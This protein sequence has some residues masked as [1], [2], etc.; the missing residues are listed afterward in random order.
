MSGIRSHADEASLIYGSY[1]CDLIRTACALLLSSPA[2]CYRAQVLFQRFNEAIDRALTS[3][4]LQRNESSGAQLPGPLSTPSVVTMLKDIM[5]YPDPE[6]KALAVLD[7]YDDTVIY[8]AGSAVLIAAKMEDSPIKIK[9]VV[10]VFDRINRRRRRDVMLL[11]IHSDPALFDLF[12]ANVIAAE[13]TMLIFLGF[14][15][16]VEYPYKFLPVFLGLIVDRA[17]Q[18]GEALFV[19]W[20]SLACGWC[21]DA[22]RFAQLA[23]KFAAPLLAC[24]A[25]A[26]TK[27]VDI[28]LPD[29]WSNAFGIDAKTLATV[30]D[31]H[32]A[33]TVSTVSS[34]SALL[35]LETSLQLRARI[36]VVAPPPPPPPPPPTVPAPPPAPEMVF[37]DFKRPSLIQQQ[38]QAALPRVVVTDTTK[39]KGSSSVALPP[40]PPP[41]PPPAASLL[42]VEEEFQDLKQ[43]QKEK[44]EREKQAKKQDKERRDK[45]DADRHRK[46]SRSRSDDDHDR[47]RRDKRDERQ[48]KRTPSRDRRDRRRHY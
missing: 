2:L 18:D 22:P 10:T 15:T 42:V 14:Q 20:L 41:T 16:F 6:G 24:A 5:L 4:K 45:P 44:R 8:F 29:G 46:R 38:Q 23:L 37:E 48:S 36:G 11:A 31:L 7:R 39:I 9:Q 17:S 3:Q 40:P 33:L 34:D 27:P 25:I 43:L 26:A 30:V 32:H 35:V 13:E 21:N 1:G 12:K 19:S 47:H 28:A